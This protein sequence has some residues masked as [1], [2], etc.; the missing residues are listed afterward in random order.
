MK[1]L[2]LSDTLQGGAGIAAARLVLKLNENGI[3]A[4]TL[5]AKD[6]SALKLTFLQSCR[7]KF[8][9]KVNKILSRVLTRFTNKDGYNVIHS[10]PLLQTGLGRALNSS[11]FDIVHFHWLGAGLMSPNEIYKLNKPIF[12]TMHD[13]WIVTGGEHYKDE[14]IIDRTAD[15][16]ASSSF[17]INY[18]GLDIDR[19]YFAIKS[20]TLFNKK[21]Y[22]ICP[23]HWM[24]NIIADSKSYLQ[25]ELRV[26]KN[27]RGEITILPKHEARSELGLSPTRKY[28]LFG[29]MNSTDDPRKGADLLHEALSK[30]NQ[31]DQKGITLLIFGNNNDLKIPQ[32]CF[33]SIPFGNVYDTE[34][35]NRLYCA[36]DVFCL[37]SRQDNLPNTAVEA[38]IRGTPVVAF[39]IGGIPEIVNDTVGGKLTPA[40]DTDKLKDNIM[41]ILN[42]NNN[43]FYISNTAQKKFDDNLH[44]KRHIMY[45]RSAVKNA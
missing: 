14:R 15:R 2:H 30:I 31:S 25:S 41:Y 8:F 20:R 13:Q 33:E 37:P 19:F 42:R 39:D 44:V 28:V 29:A 43:Q 10:Y 4:K 24:K 22:M 36:A 6:L 32:G 7:I 23:S 1:V 45:Y 38:V 34:T 9:I 5:T 27:I 18:R 35:L 3:S 12:W 40:F 26:I 11:E 17:P 21:I 16:Y